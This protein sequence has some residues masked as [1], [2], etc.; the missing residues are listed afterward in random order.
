LLTACSEVKARRQP[1][2]LVRDGP[3]W[4]IPGMSD[5]RRTQ[6]WPWIM[7]LIALPLVY[8]LSS[9]PACWLTATG[10]PK[11]VRQDPNGPVV[12]LAMRIYCPLGYL[13]GDDDNARS[14]RLLLWWMALGAPPEHSVRVPRTLD[15]RYWILFERGWV[16]FPYDH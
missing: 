3:P 10:G 6:F 2:S 8:V 11:H 9:G 7:A 16:D 13:L 15:G 12:P 4:Y 1:I 5:Q 14:K